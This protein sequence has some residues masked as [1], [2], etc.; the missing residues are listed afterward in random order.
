MDT[1]KKESAQRARDIHETAKLLVAVLNHNHVNVE[2]ALNAL[3]WVLAKTAYDHDISH[4]N[5]INS[6]A[7]TVKLVYEHEHDAREES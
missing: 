5:A 1:N 4:F 7:S 2:V 3:S 6:F